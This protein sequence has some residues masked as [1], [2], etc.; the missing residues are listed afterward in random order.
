[1]SLILKE[2]WALVYTYD[3]CQIVKHWCSMDKLCLHLKTAMI[4][5]YLKSKVRKLA[6]VHNKTLFKICLGLKSPIKENAGCI[7][8]KLD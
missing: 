1:M 7:C 8:S 6:D 4:P 3:K 2:L 5:V